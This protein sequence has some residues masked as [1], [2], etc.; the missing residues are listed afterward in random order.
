LFKRKRRSGDDVSLAG[1]EPE[2]A[3]S[4]PEEEPRGGETPELEQVP[5]DAV[6]KE[7]D[8]DGA[9]EQR[10]TDG[11]N[12]KAK[13]PRRLRRE[14]K[15]R[16]PRVPVA[17][18]SLVRRERRALMRER[19]QRIRDL[20]G[21]MLEMY[22][23]DQFRE[24]LIVE[25]CAQAMG[26]ENRIHEL[27]LILARAKSG[28]ARTGPRCACGA[29]LLFGA[30]F[31]A[32]CGRPTDLAATGELCAK[33]LQ[34]VAVGAVFCSSCGA[35]VRESEPPSERIERNEQTVEHASPSDA[36]SATEGD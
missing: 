17:N 2:H 30:H 16:P 25:H 19:E 4:R 26:V 12:A 35:L 23:R 21:L 11:E 27:D 36:A 34:P 20:G 22:R 6:A 9:D 8:T 24:D 5:A 3:L 13:R 7:S 14:K 29:P 28:R 18:L 1:P 15:E 32:N 33:C 10:E 31:C